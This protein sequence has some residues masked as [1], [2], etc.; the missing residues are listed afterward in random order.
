VRR[1]ASDISS[2]LSDVNREVGHATQ[3]AGGARCCS[4][5]RCQAN[6]DRAP[7]WCRSA[8]CGGGAVRT[9]VYDHTW[10]VLLVNV[11]PCC[12]RRPKGPIP[13]APLTPQK[14]GAPRRDEKLNSLSNE[15]ASASHMTSGKKKL[16][17]CY[18]CPAIDQARLS[19]FPSSA[20]A[21]IRLP[22]P[23]TVEVRSAPC[24][25]TRGSPR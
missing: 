16:R 18:F 7:I 22:R 20:H 5:G 19:A 25:G 14:F 11:H 15:T 21:I 13:E 10:R 8:R 1:K 23:A 17:Q 6:N 12:A 9:T 3:R 2:A 4:D 24:P